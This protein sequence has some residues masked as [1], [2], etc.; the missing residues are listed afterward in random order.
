AGSDDGVFSTTDNGATWTALNNGLTPK[1]ASA[2]AINGSTLIAGT[3]AG[4]YVS[5]DQGAHW[6]LSSAGLPPD[7]YI[8]SLLAAGDRIYAGTAG[9]G[10]YASS[11]NGASWSP[12]TT[13]L[14]SSSYILALASAGTTLY[15]GSAGSGFFVSTD[16]GAHWNEA[17][18]GLG[19]LTVNAIIVNGGTLYAGTNGG[20][21]QSDNSG[22]SWTPLNSGI[23]NLTVKTLLASGMA[24]YAGTEGSGVLRFALNDPTP[25]VISGSAG[26]EG[27]TITWVDGTE[28]TATSDAAGNYSIEVSSHWSGTVTPS[29]PNYLFR[30]ASRTYV[31]VQGSLAGENYTA[32]MT[33]TISGNTG[34]GSE[35]LTWF[36]DT[37]RTVKASPSGNYTITVPAHWSG[38]IT[39]SKLGYLFYPE[40]RSYTDVTS[41]LTT[42]TYSTWRGIIIS[43]N[44]GAPG[45]TLTW[46]DGKQKSVVSDS[47]GMYSITVSYSYNGTVTP[48]L[49]GC[50]FSPP[51]IT[52][53]SQRTDALNNNYQVSGSVSVNVKAL[54]AGA[55]SGGAMSTAL[56]A[57]GLLPLN[58]NEAYNAAVY[59]YAPKSVSSIPSSSI[60]DWVLIE[61]RTGTAASTRVAVQAGFIRNDGMIV[62]VDGSSQLPFPGIVPGSYYIAICHRNHLM[63]MTSQAVPLS[64]SSLLYDFTT[65]MEKAYGTYPMTP[66]SGSLLYGMHGGDANR[67][68]QVTGSDYN[69]FSPRFS[70]IS[71]GYDDAD[72]NMD[73]RVTGTDYNIFSPAYAAIR[74]SGVPQ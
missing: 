6:V 63:V 34:G 3:S 62:D 20:V 40:A 9:Y 50:S 70:S 44:A 31:N 7:T 21:F 42:P 68:G 72:L 33:Y 24:L 30:P 66:L 2:L 65:G 1:Y 43:G 46:V 59:N 48:V 37:V 17:N 11:D 61:L 10:L 14:P 16:N 55:W 23:T 51:R 49:P 18:T 39:P 28:K 25:V 71:S 58:S 12:A 56:N 47:A 26:V 60:V 4:I 73:G 36:D 57:Q 54:L 38:T 27:A 5:P 41:N 13:G 35:T 15:A 64:L 8:H 19:D 74:A 67:D 53:V 45:V 69:L 32:L 29:K 52:Y 22:A